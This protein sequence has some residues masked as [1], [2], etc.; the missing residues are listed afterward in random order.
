MNAPSKPTDRRNT[1]LLAVAKFLVSVVAFWLVLRAVDFH[2]L[3]RQ[4]SAADPRWIGLGLLALIAHFAV[5]VWRWDYALIRFYDLRLGLRRLSLVVGLGEAVGPALPSFVGTDVVRTFA[6][7]GSAP[8]VT[9]AK[10]VMIDRVFGMA[11][12]LVMI[13]V[14]VP[15]F[16]FLVDRGPALALVAAL[17]FGG[18]I[19]YAVGLQSGP[20][21]ARIPVVGE[22]LA[23]L[24]A[25]IRRVSVDRQAMVVLIGS[26]LLVHLTSILTFWCAARMLH[27]TVDFV[28][29][30]L[31]APAAM[32]IAAVPISIGGWG[33]REGALVAGFAL[34]G[35]DAE[36]ILAASIC[37]GLSGLVSGVIGISSLPFLPRSLASSPKK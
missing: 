3:L 11:A 15:F 7:A 27:G 31:I 1:I 23:K 17:S 32:L 2:D 6:L 29:T 18:L 22:G 14:S 24:L 30:L 33:L 19:A 13:A 9:V 8:L 16:A 4:F 12:L 28:S 36:N 25:E 10:A 20:L 35:A 21:V 34:V 5:V 37:Y 26:G